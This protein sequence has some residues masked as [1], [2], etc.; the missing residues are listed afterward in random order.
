MKCLWFMV[1]F[2]E[3]GAGLGVHEL[4][5]LRGQL[6]VA[7][8]A[9]EGAYSLPQ[10]AMLLL[11]LSVMM[12]VVEIARLAKTRSMQQRCLQQQLRAR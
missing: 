3:R 10:A 8:S 7:E 4:E 1:Q 5:K 6:V 9:S 12:M 11:S 2:G